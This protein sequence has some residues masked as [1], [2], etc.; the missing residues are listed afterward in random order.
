M[1]FQAC[2]RGMRHGAL[3]A[4]APLDLGLGGCSRPKLDLGREG[5]CTT[6]QKTLYRLDRHDAHC[7]KTMPPI[8]WR[9]STLIERALLVM[10]YPIAALGTVTAKLNYLRLRAADRRSA[11]SR[12]AG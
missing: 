8:F 1:Y 7:A 9:Q 6:K 4:D 2:F 5:C 10:S 3:R 12:G 11:K